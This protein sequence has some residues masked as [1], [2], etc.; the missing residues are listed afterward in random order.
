MPGHTRSLREVG[1]EETRRRRTDGVS[2]THGRET[3]QELERVKEFGALEQTIESRG[4]PVLQGAD[5][6]SWARAVDLEATFLWRR[7]DGV[8][9]HGCREVL[10]VALHYILKCDV[11]NRKDLYA[12]VVLHHSV[13]GSTTVP[14]GTHTAFSVSSLPQPCC[15]PAVTS[16]RPKVTS[17]TLTTISFSCL[18]TLTL[19]PLCS[20]A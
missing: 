10:V 14:P 17:T 5:E 19:R 3:I 15:G 4:D 20:K 12:N 2:W 7:Q 6:D 18:R 1:R 16:P 8:E 11:D 9:R 13:R